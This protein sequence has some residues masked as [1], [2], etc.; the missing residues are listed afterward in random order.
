MSPARIIRIARCLPFDELKQRNHQASELLRF[1]SFLMLD[2]QCE[3]L[4]ANHLA[5]V[6][7]SKFRSAESD[8]FAHFQRMKPRTNTTGNMNGSLRM[9]N[10]DI[11]YF[12]IPIKTIILTMNMRN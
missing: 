6:L 3:D 5:P 2:K 10:L 11:F 1:P 9:L 4:S 8:P 7:Q 12:S